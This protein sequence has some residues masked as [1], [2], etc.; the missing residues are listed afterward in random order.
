MSESFPCMFSSRSFILLG[1]IRS[2]IHFVCL[3]L[4]VCVCVCVCGVSWGSNFILLHMEIQFS[5]HHYPLCLLVFLSWHIWKSGS[6][7]LFQCIWFC[8][9]AS[10]VLFL[11]TL[12]LYYKLK[13]GRLMPPTLCFV[14]FPLKI[15]LAIWNL[16]Y[17]Y[18]KSRIFSTSV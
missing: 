1:Y 4:C 17:F 6:F 3:H 18:K 9:N 7:F 10:T 5:Q 12:A 15:A 8:F 13:S 11:T 14:D 16:Y 2:F